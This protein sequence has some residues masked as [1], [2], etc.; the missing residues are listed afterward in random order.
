MTVLNTGIERMRYFR[1]HCDGR[2]TLRHDRSCKIIN[3]ELIQPI[4]KD[5]QV[6]ISEDTCFLQGQLI[7]F[8]I[9]LEL[10]IRF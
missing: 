8:R 9:L 6:N 4:L 7:H 3:P 10:R 1:L 5:A 2:K